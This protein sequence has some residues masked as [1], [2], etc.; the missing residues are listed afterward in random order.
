MGDVAVDGIDNYRNY[1]N[2]A[3]LLI[4][5]PAD[6]TGTQEA[7]NII[8]DIAML[9]NA[10]VF[11]SNDG[12]KI[13]EKDLELRGPGDF[14]RDASDSAFRQSGGLKFK[15]ADITNDSAVLTAAFDA[16]RTLIDQDPNLDSYPM[17]KNR[18][19][20]VFSIDLASVN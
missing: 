4:S 5:T 7:H 11:W 6:A 13:A 9:T 17:L 14:L 20:S 15:I 19:L 3:N 18:V 2:Q 10:A 1:C 16:A 8:N 12:F